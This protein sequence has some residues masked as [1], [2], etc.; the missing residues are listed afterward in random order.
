MLSF[1]INL[2]AFFWDFSSIPQMAPLG[3]VTTRGVE[4][5]FCLVFLWL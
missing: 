4:K 1:H 2:P 5:N 3:Q